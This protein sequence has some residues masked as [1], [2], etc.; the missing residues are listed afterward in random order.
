MLCVFYYNKKKICSQKKSSFCFL[1]N[2]LYDAVQQDMSFS[3]RQEQEKSTVKSLSKVRQL[4]PAF[5]SHF[6]KVPCGPELVTLQKTSYKT[7]EQKRNTYKK[8][9]CLKK[10]RIGN[11]MQQVFLH[12]IYAYVLLNC[13]S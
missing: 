4:W 6:G 10:S 13:N 5:C 11:K 7:V 2:S 12:S 1:S 9:A 3:D 8:G